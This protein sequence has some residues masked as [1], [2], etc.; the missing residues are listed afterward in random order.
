[1]SETL[2]TTEM[3]Q[4]VEALE[5]QGF[6]S[7]LAKFVRQHPQFAKKLVRKIERAVM[8]DISIGGF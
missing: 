4:F 2:N 5:R 3:R 8:E 7:G 6:H 1:M